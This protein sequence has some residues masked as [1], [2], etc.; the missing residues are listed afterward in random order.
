ML[1]L[2]DDGSS[3]ATTATVRQLERDIQQVAERLSAVK[4]EKITQQLE[5]DI[6]ETLGSLIEALADARKANEQKK[7]QQS[8]KSG[9]DAGSPPPGEQPLV[10]QLAELKLIRGMQ[11]QILKRHHR[12]A[13]LLEHPDDPVG[14]SAQPDIQTGLDKLQERQKRLAAI[15]PRNSRGG[16]LTDHEY[17]LPLL[18]R[19]FG[20]WRLIGL[21][22]AQPAP[23]LDENELARASQC[24]SRPTIRATAH[25]RVGPSFRKSSTGIV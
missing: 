4:V 19:S 21:A 12:Y 14:F 18:V 16:N 8:Q 13:Q 2:E 22:S 15:D 9:D 23:L 11:Q 5:Q 20:S 24:K 1:V 17:L 3:I 6:V 25:S 10:S 7:D